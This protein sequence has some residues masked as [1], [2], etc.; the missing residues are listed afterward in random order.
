MCITPSWASLFGEQEVFIYHFEGCAPA[1]AATGIVT[2]VR[3]ARQSLTGH[4][5]RLCSECLLW[6]IGSAFEQGFQSSVI[7]YMSIELEKASITRSWGWN[8]QGVCYFLHALGEHASPP[9]FRNYRCC[10]PQIG[11]RW[12]Q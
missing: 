8:F 12:E 5:I 7:I 11:D 9:R 10:E 4:A 1:Y 2:C 6:D 3:P